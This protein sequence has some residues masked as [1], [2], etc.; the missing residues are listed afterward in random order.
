MD[1]QENAQRQGKH[2]SPK[3][4]TF[5]FMHET[6]V[7]CSIDGGRRLEQAIQVLS[8]P[9]TDFQPLLFE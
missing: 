7:I 8:G 2:H 1:D 5:F 4:L 3:L 9:P 6:L